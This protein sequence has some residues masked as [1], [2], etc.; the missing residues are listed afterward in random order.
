M[1]NSL[2]SQ[3]ISTDEYKIYA[4]ILDE[5][6]YP[7]NKFYL[8]ISSNQKASLL[9]RK[10]PI[11]SKIAQL[12]S[13]KT[14]DLSRL[15]SYIL[16]FRN[17]RSLNQENYIDKLKDYKIKVT[18][19]NIYFK[20]DTEAY[21]Y[22]INEFRNLKPMQFLTKATKKHDGYWHLEPYTFYY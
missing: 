9:V 12:N 6:N 10:D 18:C 7:S 11:E 15:D 19:S 1:S 2:F 20:S 16:K 5:L 14:F 4:Q 22:G 3:E 17:D 13:K 21:I 8:G